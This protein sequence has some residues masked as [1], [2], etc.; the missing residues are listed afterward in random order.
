MPTT[1]ARWLLAAIITFV[2]V[3]TLRAENWPQWRG[4]DGD[5]TSRDTGMPVAWTEES[6]VVWKCKLPQWGNSTPIIWGDAIFL[7]SHVDD[8]DL[9][10]LRISKKTGQIVW[11]RKVGSGSCKREHERVKPDGQHGGQ[12]F[13]PE[14]NMASPSVVTDGEV[15]ITHFGNG[16]LAAY[17]FDGNQL[18]LR[19][20][21]KDYGPYTIWW[22]HANSPVLYGK[23]VISV[24]IQDTLADL[25]GEPSPSYL[26]AHDKR[27]GRERWRTLRP[28]TAKA[29]DGDS[30]VTPLFRRTPERLELILWGG[31]ILDAYEPVHGERLWYLTNLTGSRTI[32][33][34]VAAGDMIYAVQGMKRPLLAVRPGGDG[35]RSR[36]DVVWKLEQGVPDGPTP[37]VCGPSLYLVTNE[38]IARCLDAHTG[39]SHWKERLRGDYRASPLAVE[40][41]IYFLNTAGLCTVVSA[42]TRYDRL[43]ENRLNDITRASPAVS[44]GKLFIRGRKWL[45]CIAK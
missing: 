42:S 9:L 44:D 25:P 19:N 23:M 7:T 24:C 30:Y 26:V 6:G 31:Q 36:K 1:P 15:V 10:L 37:V 13:N 38:G 14:H 21:Q 33:G 8:H 32:T 45:Y 39:R 22:G 29:E 43:T 3:A 34:P 28:T 5:G 41:R 35:Q 16:D 18:W 27:T 17:D 11:T 4:P 12:A 20:L 40:G 2:F